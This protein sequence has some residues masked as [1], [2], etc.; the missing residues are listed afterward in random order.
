MLGFAPYNKPRAAVFLGDVGSLP[1]GLL[2]GTAL[3]GLA[4]AGHLAAAILLA[5][6]PCVDATATLARR[7][8]RREKVWQAHRSHYYQQA[9]DNGFT[10][11]E[12]SAHVFAL[13]V[14]LAALAGVTVA[15]A[16]PWVDALVTCF[17]LALT[18]ALCARFTRQR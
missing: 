10:A 18:A 5:A 7:A 16:A 17:G 14:G 15:I 3:I 13:N 11:L 6:Y 9:T 1:I 8:Y 4:G 2:A 12:V